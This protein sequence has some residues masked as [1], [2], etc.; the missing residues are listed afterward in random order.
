MAKAEGLTYRFR[1]EDGCE[2]LVPEDRL[3]HSAPR[4]APNR[5]RRVRAADV[6]IGDLI[7]THLGWSA[8]ADLEER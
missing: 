1:C 3:V 7:E 5:R 6:S 4:W 8:V 2:M